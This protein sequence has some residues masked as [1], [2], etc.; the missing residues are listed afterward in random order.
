MIRSVEVTELA[1]AI[2]TAGEMIG[3]IIL[4]GIAVFAAGWYSAGAFVVLAI[5]ITAA[6]RAQEKRSLRWE[7]LY[8]QTDDVTT[9]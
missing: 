1:D 8:S 6:Y 3:S 7:R 4:F 5:W 9:E 2:S